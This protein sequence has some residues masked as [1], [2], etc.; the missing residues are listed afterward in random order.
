MNRH[1]IGQLQILQQGEAV[2]GQAVV[3]GD[4]HTFVAEGDLLNR[5]D[6]TVKN[7]GADLGLALFC[8]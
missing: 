7:T 8:P 4:A 5:A 1:R 3:K 6:I 2:L